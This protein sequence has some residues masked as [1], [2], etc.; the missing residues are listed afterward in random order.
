MKKCLLFLSVLF[1]AIGQ[2]WGQSQT[3]SGTVLNEADDEPII[4]ASIQV[5]GTSKGTITDVD[6]KFSIEAE[7]EA[8][9]VVSFIGMATQEVAAKDGVVIS[10]SE[11]T[12]QLDEVMVVAFG[13]ST[14]KSFP[15]VNH[16]LF[17][18]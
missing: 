6:G 8:V 11:D 4:G 7:P 12:K 2:V 18:L 3:I 13:T 16:A 10:L 9:L 5:K 1:I 17:L 14:K 15:S